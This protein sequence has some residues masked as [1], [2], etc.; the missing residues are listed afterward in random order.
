MLRES[1]V[2]FLITVVLIGIGACVAPVPVDPEPPGES[3]VFSLPVVDVGASGDDGNVP[4]NVLDGDL[5]T[6]WSSSGIGEWISF[7]LDDV[8]EV[9]EVRVSWYLG[10]SRSWFFDVYYSLD[11]VLW[12]EVF[13]GSSGGVSVEPESYS[14]IDAAA[15]YVRIVGRGNDRPSTWNS[16]TTVGLYGRGA[17]GDTLYLDYD[18][19]FVD[20]EPPEEPP[21]DPTPPPEEPVDPEPPSDPAP[22]SSGDLSLRGNPDFHRNQLTSEQRVWYDR[23]IDAIENPGSD[24]DPYRIAARDDLYRYGRPL[25]I[26]L[27]SVLLA[28]RATG[29]LRLLDHVDEITTI[30]RG[31]LRDGWRDTK[32]GTDG[33]KDGYV[34]WVW[35]YSSGDQ[36]IGKDTNVLDE[37]KTHA[38][39]AMIAVALDTNRDLSSPAGRNYGE[40]A[41]F[42]EYYLVDHFEAKWRE[43]T[44]RP[45]GLPFMMRTGTHTYL[46][47]MKWHYYMERLTGNHAYR[48][49]ADKMAESWW[50]EVRSVNTAQGVAYVWPRGIIG[51]GSG[52]DY[53]MP[54]VYASMVIADMVELHMEG[55]GRW[56]SES[57]I[58]RFTLTFTR[59]MADDGFPIKR[60]VGGEQPRAGLRSEAENW[61]WMT[62]HGFW[63]SGYPHLAAWD[64]GDVMVGLIDDAYGRKGS[65]TGMMLSAGALLAA[66]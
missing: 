3:D 7:E 34:N 23:V 2:L 42:W 62:R 31:E 25:H 22:P 51:E 16:I 30:M 39:I 45:S 9:S 13:S 63:L 33:T 64:D 20:P 48:V 6:R 46:S 60:D 53:L 4:L 43:R 38:M 49:Q 32:D 44:N 12:A 55:Y 58:R 47:W 8:Y 61:P 66:R 37:I 50:G 40:S 21:S 57:E 11:G 1:L 18:V 26:Y 10:D 29:D 19:S 36:F 35:R 54:T 14:L 41:D 52:A 65:H 24:L 28:F 27:Q 56:G 17:D 15:R 59:L 5:G